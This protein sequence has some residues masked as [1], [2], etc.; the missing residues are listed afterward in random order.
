MTPRE[1]ARDPAWESDVL[2]GYW[3]Q[4]LPTRA[5]TRT[6]R[7]ELVATLVRRGDGPRGRHAVL[8]LHGY[9]D[10]FFNTELA[11]HFAERGFTFYAL[12]LHKCGRSRQPGQTPH[13]TT[14]L[15][16]YDAELDRAL[17]VDRRRRRR[18]RRGPG[19][20]RTATRRAG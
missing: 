3:Q 14:N 11:D 6:V 2:P 20:R 7:V 4:T 17:A 9:T 15:A 1:P 10:Y 8:A 16:D 13:F 19:L 12:D 18:G 5:W